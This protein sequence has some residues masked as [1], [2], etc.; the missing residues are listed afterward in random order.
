MDAVHSWCS[1][2]IFRYSC[3]NETEINQKFV[4][5]IFDQWQLFNYRGLFSLI[6]RVW[7]EMMEL[8]KQLHR[9]SSEFH[10]RC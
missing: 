8:R 4:Q 3:Y 2:R 1:D 5:I 7:Y 9:I 6:G 10:V